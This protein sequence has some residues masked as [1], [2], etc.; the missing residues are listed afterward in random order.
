MVRALLIVVTLCISSLAGTRLAHSANEQTVEFTVENMTC[1]ACPITVMAAMKR[2][3]GVLEVRI[4]RD[5]NIATV[6]FDPE[7]TSPEE[8]G[9]A[10]ANAG[11]PASVAG[12]TG[13]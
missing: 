13:Q 9:A 11:Y 1:A 10:S 6:V 3:D 8:I 4:D 7:K 2:V 5:T 12:G